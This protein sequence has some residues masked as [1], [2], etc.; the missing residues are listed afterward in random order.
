VSALLLVFCGLVWADPPELQDKGKIQDGGSALHVDWNASPTTADW[1]NDGAK[2][3]IVGEAD[4]GNIRLYLNQ[5]TD[6]NPVFN[7]YTQ[8]EMNGNPIAMTWSQ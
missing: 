1:N 3:L 6:L 7:G 4:G 2:D 5:G 8:L